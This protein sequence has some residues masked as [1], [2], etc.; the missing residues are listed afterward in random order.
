MKEAVGE[1]SRRENIQL[2]ALTRGSM[3][4][5]TQKQPPSP[6]S[7]WLVVKRSNKSSDHKQRPGWGLGK[8]EGREPQNVSCRGT[9]Q[10]LVCSVII[11]ISNS[12][13]TEKERLEHKVSICAAQKLIKNANYH[14]CPTTRRS[15]ETHAHRWWL[16]WD[17]QNT[18][19]YHVAVTPTDYLS[20]SQEAVK[21]CLLH[22]VNLNHKLHKPLWYNFNHSPH[23][24]I[25]LPSTDMHLHTAQ[26]RTPLGILQRATP[27]SQSSLPQMDA[28]SLQILSR[29]SL[30]SRTCISAS[31]CGN[32][33]W[34]PVEIGR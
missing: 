6:T 18:H 13:Q 22:T 29:V 11:I 25:T 7:L 32:T 1:E 30:D 24:P 4:H 23:K 19:Q 3:S 10:T 21:G 14:D 12:T 26:R 20:H 17:G 34:L 27:P 33:S 5:W 28:A 8:R 2:K 9:T 15:P 16:V 31:Q